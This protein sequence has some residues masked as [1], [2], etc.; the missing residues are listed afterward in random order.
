MQGFFILNNQNTFSRL[1]GNASFTFSLIWILGI[2]LLSFLSPC[3]APDNSENANTQNIENAGKLSGKSNG[4]FHLLGTDRFGRDVLSRLMF[5]GKYSLTVGFVSVFI[6][7]SIGTTLGLM[8][9][10]YGGIIDKFILWFISVIWSVPLM[11]FVIAITLVLGKGMFPLFLAIGFATWVDLARVVRGQVIS[12]KQLE[13]IEACKA[14][15]FT[16]GRILIRH[17]LPNIA[18]TLLVLCSAN[19]ASAI[20]LESGLSF[21]GLGAQPP[22]P[23]WGNMIRDHIGYLFNGNYLVVIAPSA[24]IFLSVLSFTLIGN[25]LR[26][27]LTLK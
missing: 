27:F 17:I 9:G 20:L 12:I 24:A 16:D 7:L 22:V 14:F 6:S 21:L 25:T 1:V 23:T 3:L 2:C 15:G 10:Y 18:S 19:F 13:F 5:G 26:D 4:K 11:L 8:A